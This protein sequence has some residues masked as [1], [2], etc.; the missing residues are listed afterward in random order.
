MRILITGSNGQVGNSFKRVDLPCNFEIFPLDRSQLDISDRD[1]IKK[2]LA[3]IRPQ[4]LINAA[5]YT[6]VD[7]AEEEYFEAHVSNELGPKNLAISCLEQGIPLFHISTDYVFDGQFNKPYSESDIAN[8]QG[9]YAKSKLAGE[10]YVRKI[11]PMHI[12]LRTS[13][14]FSDHGKNFPK[15]ILKISQDKDEIRVV[16][17]QK[18]GPTSSRSIV[19]ILLKLAVQYQNENFLQWGTFHFS[20]L[21]YC[22][23]YDLAAKICHLASEKYQKPKVKVIPICSAEFPTKAIRPAN[24]M[25][26]VTKLR[27]IINIESELSWEIDLELV[28][29]KLMKSQNNSFKC[30]GS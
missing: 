4:L 22:S 26:N 18:G 27:S 19:D 17:D 11:H 20:Q 5:A 6:N 16:A 9:I 7:K 21:P 29:S 3:E 30:L 25:L 28:I 14:V 8:P 23:W 10:E 15:T 1:N 13:W 2:T 24:S 12:I